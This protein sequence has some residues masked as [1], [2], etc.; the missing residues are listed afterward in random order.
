MK[1]FKRKIKQL[2]NTTGCLQIGYDFVDLT[3]E[4]YSDPIKAVSDMITFDYMVTGP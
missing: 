1:S 3:S 2:F 4:N